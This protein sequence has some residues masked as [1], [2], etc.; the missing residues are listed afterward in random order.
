MPGSSDTYSIRSRLSGKVLS[1]NS[2]A[3]GAPVIQWTNQGA[4][5]QQWQQIPITGGYKYRNVATGLYLDVSGYSYAAGARLVQ[6]YGT[7]GLNQQFIVSS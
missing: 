2:Y 3:A 5:S 7:N 1:V 6:W 4:T